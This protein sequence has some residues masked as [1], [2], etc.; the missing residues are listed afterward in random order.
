MVSVG[1]LRRC[2]LENGYKVIDWGTITKAEHTN[3]P[4]V[5]GVYALYWG[6]TLQYIGKAK[7]FYSRMIS[8]SNE[9]DIPFGSFAWFELPTEEV[10]GAE[11][12]LIRE[13]KPPYNSNNPRNPDDDD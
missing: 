4:E 12:V 13:Y 3:A 1:W 6:E 10:A 5:S 2:L 9:G 11:A 8:W 7:S